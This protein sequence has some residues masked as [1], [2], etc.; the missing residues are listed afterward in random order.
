MENY[1]NANPYNPYN[2]DVSGQE[3]DQNQ[4]GQPFYGQAQQQAYQQVQDQGSYGQTAYTQPMNQNQQN[5]G[6]YNQAQQYG[7]PQADQ[8]QYPQ[9]GQG[10]QSQYG[11]TGY[12]TQMSQPA[13]NN[14][15]QAQYQQPQQ[16]Q[17]FNQFG[18]YNQVNQAPN[19]GQNQYNQQYSQQRQQNYT[20][21]P[22]PQVYGQGQYQSFP[23][24]S[25]T[26]NNLGNQN[27]TAYQNIKK[28]AQ[29]AFAFS[30]AGFFLTG[31]R[32]L[33]FFFGVYS[34]FRAKTGLKLNQDFNIGHEY[35]SKLKFAMVLGIVDIVF[36]IILML[37]LR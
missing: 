4:Y 29:I 33:G 28:A 8:Y 32:S 18:Q 9:Y 6:A 27:F 7:M 16:G 31:I 23:Q 2:Q 13:Q 11:H 36:A 21:A 5:Y 10:Q 37:G 12:T 34:L 35:V 19:Y 22:T 14:Y 24:T 26:Y 15:Q 1:K 30:I 17:G 25:Q 20:F 3:P